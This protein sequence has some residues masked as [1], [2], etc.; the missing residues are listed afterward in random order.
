[1]HTLNFGTINLAEVGL[2]H[3]FVGQHIGLDIGAATS[4]KVRLSCNYTAVGRQKQQ[5]PKC[6]TIEINK[7]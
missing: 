2:H 6:K 1:M 5:Q 4:D 3:G 7:Q